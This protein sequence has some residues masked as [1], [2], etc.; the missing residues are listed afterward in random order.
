MLQ[1]IAT[2]K[3]EMNKGMTR[4]E[5][6]TLMSELFSVSSKEAENHFDY[7]IKSK[8]F[9]ELKRGGHVVSAQAT[10][11][12]RTAITMSYQVMGTCIYSWF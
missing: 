10:T 6:I 2:S 11:T 5:M 8:Q 1:S 3:N 7:L 12:N 9:P 4:K